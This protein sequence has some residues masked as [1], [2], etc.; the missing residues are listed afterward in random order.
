MYL[1]QSV[2]RKVAFVAGV[3]NHYI[4]AK[5]RVYTSPRAARKA[6][7]SIMSAVVH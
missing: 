1:I 2:F 6:Q 7:R 5:P 4:I 3:G